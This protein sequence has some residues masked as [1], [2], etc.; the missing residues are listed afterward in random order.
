MMMNKRKE[1]K[2][3]LSKLLAI[4]GWVV[5]IGILFTGW[6]AVA[7]N[8]LDRLTNEL[9]DAS[10]ELN[11]ASE[12][13]NLLQEIELNELNYVLS[14][15]PEYNHVH[16]QLVSH[17]KLYIRNS[18]IRT[19][20]KDLQ[21]TLTQV[22]T[23]F[24]AYL[25]LYEEVV[26]AGEENDWDKALE[27]KEESAWKIE[28]TQDQINKVFHHYLDIT[29]DRSES[30]SRYHTITGVVGGVAI[31]IYVVILFLTSRILMNQISN[32]I[33]QMIEA[34]K[35]VEENRFKAKS[36]KGLTERGDE[37]GRLARA[38]IEMNKSFGAREQALE[39]EIADV[40]AK[41][42]R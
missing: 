12:I 15:D 9:V 23:E 39:K 18:L 19:E 2:S 40:R 14:Q 7:M 17:T 11:G 25:V 41:V 20:E 1:Q 27:L 4:M 30:V 28:E 34:G 38:F 24:L 26:E 42:E 22:E 16:D 5:F 35:D 13:L 36:L 3:I 31:L 10:N 33:I 6:S 8:Q 21:F 29:I 32:P 37:V